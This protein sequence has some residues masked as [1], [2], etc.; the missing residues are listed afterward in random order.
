M[1]FVMNPKSNKRIQSQQRL[2]AYARME[3]SGEVLIHNEEEFFIAPLNNLSA[4]GCFVNKLMSIPEGT[5]VRLVVR[6]PRLNH[7]IQAKGNVV[8]VESQNRYG[9][10]I[11]FTSIP[12]IDREA[13]QNLVY[14]NKLQNALKVI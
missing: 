10:A 3:L 2:R 14:E 8:R 12:Q 6:S 13:I 7:P 1:R 11:E 9:S 5:E 4:G